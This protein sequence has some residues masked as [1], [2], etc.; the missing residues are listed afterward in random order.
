MLTCIEVIEKPKRTR[1]TIF[2]KN[3]QRKQT[4]TARNLIMIN[5]VQGK[6][7][8]PKTF[9]YSINHS[10]L[11]PSRLSCLLVSCIKKH[12]PL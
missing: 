9:I 3:I 7:N 11:I 5:D 6:T 2:S 8:K 12:I 1:G 10:F 4:N